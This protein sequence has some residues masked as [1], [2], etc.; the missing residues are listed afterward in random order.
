MLPATAS[1]HPLGNFTVN[2][3]SLIDV[4]RGSVSVRFV[5]DMAEIPTFQAL[6]GGTRDGRAILYAQREAPAGC[7][8]STCGRRPASAAVA[9]PGQ[10]SREPSP[11][12]GG[13]VDHAR[14]THGHRGGLR[15]GV[16]RG[17]LPRGR[18]SATRSAGARSSSDH[19]D[20]VV[21]TGSTAATRDVSDMLRHYPAGLLQSPLDESSASL[22]YR[23]GSGRERCRRTQ[24]AVRR[25]RRGHIRVWLHLAG[26]SPPPDSRVH[27][28]RAAAGDGMG[29]APCTQPGARQVDRGGVPD[30]VARYGPPR[31][32][33]GG[34]RDGDP[35]GGRRG[36]SAW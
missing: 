19:S 10:R 35:H 25:R 20:G 1:A 22:T 13:P 5:V 11:W 27:R 32:V 12:P 16:A 8:G 23:H 6:G 3:Y 30:R 14:R 31:G 4:G 24:A 26:R 21:L 36:A 29:R 34:D 18:A 15:G 2:R 17:D 7:A 9:R 28:A 33:P